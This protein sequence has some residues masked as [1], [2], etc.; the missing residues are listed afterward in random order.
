[1][2]IAHLIILVI[3]LGVIVLIWS[4]WLT[5]ETA[6]EIAAQEF[7][8]A[9]QQVTDGCGFNCQGCGVVAV[10]RLLFGF[11]VQVEYAC[12]LLPADEPQYHQAARLYV[13]PLK[14][15]HGVPSP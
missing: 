3:L 12:G 11:S 10:R 8:A 4:P 15:V 2:K 5:V 14:S 7:T 1:M 13:S 9:W 6:G